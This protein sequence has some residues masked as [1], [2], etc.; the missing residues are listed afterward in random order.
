MLHLPIR[1]FWE[2]L[3]LGHCQYC[4]DCRL[5]QE[6]RWGTIFACFETKIS[7][8]EEWWVEGE[9]GGEYFDWKTDSL[10]DQYIFWIFGWKRWI[11]VC[12]GYSVD[13]LFGIGCKLWDLN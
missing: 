9:A 2:Y 1:G 8:S 13:Q 7:G 11:F 10:E 5:D 12:A 4:V 6:N 3:R